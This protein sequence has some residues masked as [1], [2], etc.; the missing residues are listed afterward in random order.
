[1][2]FYLMGLIHGHWDR[3]SASAEQVED[4]L[5]DGGLVN[6]GI[7]VVVPVAKIAEVLSRPDLVEVRNRHIEEFHQQAATAA[8]DVDPSGAVDESAG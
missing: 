1:M 4:S 8:L 3:P 6:M 7:A 2:R 5:S